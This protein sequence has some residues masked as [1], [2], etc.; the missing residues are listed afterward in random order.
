ALDRRRAGARARSNAIPTPSQLTLRLR[1]HAWRCDGAREEGSSRTREAHSRA[2]ESGLLRGRTPS[3]AVVAR[4]LWRGAD[5]SSGEARARTVVEGRSVRRSA[6]TRTAAPFR[7]SPHRA[8]RKYRDFLGTAVG[9]RLVYR[10]G[11]N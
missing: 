9:I 7:A 11:M 6:L 3:A 2:P 1:V 5:R 10:S 8:C 4:A